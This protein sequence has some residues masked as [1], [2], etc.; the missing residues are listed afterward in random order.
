M[1]WKV[2][3]AMSSLE[4]PNREY[5]TVLNH[6]QSGHWTD[7]RIQENRLDKGFP[8]TQECKLMKVTNNPKTLNPQF[9]TALNPAR[10]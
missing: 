6:F 3:Q 9:W 8:R 5:G 1:E 7:S 4:M 10:K 2:M